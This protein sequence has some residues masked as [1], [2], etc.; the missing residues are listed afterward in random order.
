MIVGVWNESVVLVIEL[1]QDASICLA[2]SGIGNGCHAMEDDR[3]ISGLVL[4]SY[5]VRN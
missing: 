5:V 4:V 2:M 1:E 3:L